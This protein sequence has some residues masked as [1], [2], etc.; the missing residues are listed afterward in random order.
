[1]GETVLFRWSIVEFWRG[2]LQADDVSAHI[3]GKRQPQAVNRHQRSTSSSSSASETRSCLRNDRNS[4]RISFA[5]V[6]ITWAARPQTN[7][8]PAVDL[9]KL[10]GIQ[11]SRAARPHLCGKWTCF[12]LRR[13]GSVNA[14]VLLGRNNDNTRSPC[15]QQTPPP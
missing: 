2:R 9:S 7:I 12:S 8:F 6:V 14:T 10:T 4:T 1:M 3:A 13:L 15:A 11:S 5:K